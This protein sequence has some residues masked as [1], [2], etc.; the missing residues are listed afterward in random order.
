MCWR[1]LSKKLNSCRTEYQRQRLSA[2]G[3]GQSSGEERAASLLEDILE[4]RDTA[5]VLK[6]STLWSRRAPPI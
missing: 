2:F 3:I 6:R 1:S 5:S 4:T